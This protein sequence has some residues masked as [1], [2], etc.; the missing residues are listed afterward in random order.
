MRCR[1]TYIN[2]HLLVHAIIHNQAM[3]QPDAMGFHGMT[4]DIGK[5]SYIGVIEISDL[6]GL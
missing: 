3:R 6:L 5:V 2:L 1:E 4:S